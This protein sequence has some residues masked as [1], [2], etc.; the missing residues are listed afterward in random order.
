MLSAFF[1]SLASTDAL[2]V[3]VAFVTNTWTWGG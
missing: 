3:I 2:A 1:A